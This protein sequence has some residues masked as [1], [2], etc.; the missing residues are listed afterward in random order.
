MLVQPHVE[1]VALFGGE[2]D[3]V[4]LRL[5]ELGLDRHRRRIGIAD[6]AREHAP[7]AAAVGLGEFIFGA[8]ELGFGC[9]AGQPALGAGVLAGVLDRSGARVVEDE[10]DELGL[11]GA[12]IVFTQI[13]RH[14]NDQGELGQVGLY[15]GGQRER[16]LAA[17]VAQDHAALA[18]HQGIIGPAH[19]HTT[20]CV[21]ARH[22]SR[23]QRH[24]CARHVS[25]QS[26][27]P[28]PP[29]TTHTS[30]M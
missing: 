26:P 18:V 8:T 1:I 9:R 13:G 10:V 12:D 25:S 19:V 23:H 15:I 22:H 27:L 16:A 5:A 28:S 7:L 3:D 2:D 11:H 6:L 24:Q 29:S 17:E 21:G 20:E 30:Q 4:V 14:R